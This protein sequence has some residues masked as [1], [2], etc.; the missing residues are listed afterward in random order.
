M[1]KARLATF[2]WALAALVPS[3]IAQ[4]QLTLDVTKITCLQF[5]TVKIVNRQHLAF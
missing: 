2:G 3:P 4:A 1:K 5:V